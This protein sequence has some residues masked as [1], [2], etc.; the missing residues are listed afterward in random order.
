MENQSDLS[1]SS[2]STIDFYERTDIKL[3]HVLSDEYKAL[4]STITVDIGVEYLAV[5]ASVGKTVFVDF[6]GDYGDFVI[7]Q[8][9]RQLVDG[10]EVT[11][12]FSFSESNAYV[13]TAQAERWFAETRFR[14]K[15]AI[16]RAMDDA[17][18]I[19]SQTSHTDSE[20]SSTVAIS[21]SLYTSEYFSVSS[22]SATQSSAST[23]SSSSGFLVLRGSEV[24]L[25]T[26][27]VALGTL[28]A[29][30]CHD[31]GYL[32]QKRLNRNADVIINYSGVF[33]GVRIVAGTAKLKDKLLI[34]INLS[35]TSQSYNTTVDAVRL[36]YRSVLRQIS[37]ALN[38][39]V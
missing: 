22:G 39:L 32:D 14:I 13:A 36:W 21:A 23:D 37:R 28:R 35:Y 30:I 5:L 11:Q 10:L 17:H 4:F 34:E 25:T 1:T 2:S 8:S 15:T 16:L 18:E 27:V 3:T 24:A 19:F 33:N 38:N 31:I 29:S 20:S 26:K 6:G 9:L 12:S 7:P